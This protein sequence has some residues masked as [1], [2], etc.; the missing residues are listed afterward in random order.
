M[1]NHDQELQSTNQLAVR[2]LY[3]EIALIIIVKDWYKT[4]EL[5][6]PFVMGGNCTFIG[7]I[8]NIG[9]SNNY[10]PNRNKMGSNYSAPCTL[11]PAP[12]TLQV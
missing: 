4:S 5:C 9:D 12:C 6:F 1:A 8:A 10:G 11:H 2:G 3:D 7:V